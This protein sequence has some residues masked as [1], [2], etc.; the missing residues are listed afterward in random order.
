MRQRRFYG[1]DNRIMV[2]GTGGRTEDGNLEL[3]EW[4]RRRAD[5][6]AETFF[7]RSFNRRGVGPSILIS[8]GYSK[9]LFPDK[10]PAHREAPLMAKY[11]E[12]TYGI[13]GSQIAIEDESTDTAENFINSIAGYPNF[14]EAVH[15][16][17]L[18][19]VSQY[20]HLRERV[21]GAGAIEIAM[22]DELRNTDKWYRLLPANVPAE[23]NKLI[24]I[25][26]LTQEAVHLAAD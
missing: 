1:P 24:E 14:F 23:R 15:D 19:L 18:G 6:V 12:D 16:R 13:C 10:P 25:D 5:K 11:L 8:G 7:N 17:R 20:N 3:T 22:S 9:T 21:I 26:A 4:G 2:F